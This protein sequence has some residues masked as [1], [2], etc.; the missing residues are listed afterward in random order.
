MIGSISKGV[1]AAFA[2]TEYCFL[3]TLA[4]EFRW[5]EGVGGSDGSGLILGDG[6]PALEAAL[7]LD[8][9]APGLGNFVSDLRE[10]GLVDLAFFWGG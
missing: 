2:R 4:L 10:A 9:V 6:A 8:V 3:P 1:S 7:A 5:G